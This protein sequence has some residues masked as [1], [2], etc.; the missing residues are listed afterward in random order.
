MIRNLEETSLAGLPALTTE[1]YDGWLL[2]QS[3][4]YTRRAN[5]VWPLYA[6]TLKI[7]EKI[8]YC[9]ARYSDVGLPCVFKLVSVPKPRYLASEG[10]FWGQ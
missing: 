9:E 1:F 5:S 8:A 10:R 7:E 6:S 3:R 2:R 4:G